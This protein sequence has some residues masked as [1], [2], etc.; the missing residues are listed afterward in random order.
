MNQSQEC[1]VSILDFF[2]ERLNLL[3]I[4]RAEHKNNVDD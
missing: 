1:M 4:A 3:Y 2:L